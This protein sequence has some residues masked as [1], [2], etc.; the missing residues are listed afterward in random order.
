MGFGVRAGAVRERFGNSVDLMLENGSEIWRDVGEGVKILDAMRDAWDADWVLASGSVYKDAT[1]RL[2]PWLKWVRDGQA[3]QPI[4]RSRTE[5][6]PGGET[7]RHG[8]GE[9][10]IWR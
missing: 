3:V 9:L 4:L 7:T 1:D 2:R 8:Y 10:S 5:D 6:R